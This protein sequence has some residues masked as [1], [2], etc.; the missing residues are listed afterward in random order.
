MFSIGDFASYGRVSVRMLRHYDALGLLQPARTDQLTG[1]RWYEARQLSRLNR[2]VAL[3]DL[4]FTLEQVGS[5]LDD[6]VS[7]EELRGMLRLRRA[8]LQ[9]QVTA[10]IARLTQV[11]ARL[12]IIEREGAMPADDVQVK[13]IPAVR[14]AEL[15]G[16]AAGFEPESIAPVIGPLYDVLRGLLERA[17][18]VAV[19]PPVAYYEATPGGDGVF[20]HAAMPVN[21]DLPGGHAFSIVDLPEIEQAATIVH[22]GSMDN[23]VPTIQ[24]M[25]QWIEANGYRSVG[26]NREMYIEVGAD[27]D[28]WVTELQEPIELTRG[29]GT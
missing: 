23:V 17:G 1:Y 21:A 14:V 22:H 13:R 27:P 6:K 8:E 11:E 7:A 16:T 2:I 15:T 10:G 19:G 12:Q 20:V 9:A 28:A 29:P 25:A 4:G 26:Y 18:I 3:K 24:T 5:I